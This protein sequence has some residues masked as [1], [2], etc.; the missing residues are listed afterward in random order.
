MFQCFSI[1]ENIVPHVTQCPKTIVLKEM[2]LYA[3]IY[4]FNF[5]FKEGIYAQINFV[6]MLSLL[7]NH[8]QGTTIR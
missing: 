5:T 1:H 8:S 4:F 7:P 3:D 6:E 2:F